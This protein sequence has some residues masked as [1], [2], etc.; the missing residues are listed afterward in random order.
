MQGEG[1]IML[2]PPAGNAG[3]DQVLSSQKT[4]RFQV[5][6]GGGAAGWMVA[7]IL[8]WR[9]AWKMPT[10]ASFKTNEVRVAFTYDQHSGTPR[11]ILAYHAGD[12]LNQEL[13][14]QW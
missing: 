8:V 13:V 9:I 1:P 6:N 11:G 5:C 7:R 3:N 12:P 4:T 2:E 14:G 10:Y